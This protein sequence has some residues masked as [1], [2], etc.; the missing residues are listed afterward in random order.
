M[1]KPWLKSYGTNIPE[2]IDTGAFN[3]VADMFGYAFK[4]YATQTAF[5][6]LGAELSFSEVDAH[7]RNFAAYLQSEIGLKKGDRVAVMLPNILAFPIVFSG[8]MRIGAIQVNVNPNYTAHELQHQL[9]DSSAETIVVF[10]GSTPALASVLENTSVRHVIVAQL[11]DFGNDSTD[12]PDCDPSLSDAVRLPEAVSRGRDHDF[13]PPAISPDDT[14]F[15]Q[16]TGGTTGLSKGAVLSHGNLVANTEQVKAMIPFAI[17]PAE[18]VVVT[19]LPLY[20]IFGLMVNLITYFP[21][22]ARNHL[23][24]N[25]S[26]EKELIGAYRESK[27]SVSTGV[28]TLFTKLLNTPGFHDIDF[29]NCRLVMGGGTPTLPVTSERWKAA[30]GSH[31]REAYGMSETSPMISVNP[32]TYDD[33]TGTVGLPVPS[34]DIKLLGSGDV[35]ASIG[36]EGEVCVKGPQVMS[37]YW[38]KDDDKHEWYTPDGYFRTGDIGMFDEMGLLKIVDR[39]KDLVIVSGFNVF[40]TEI[41]AS[42][43]RMD[44]VVEC[45]AIGIP[46]EKTGEAIRLFVVKQSDADITE[47]DVINHC[48]TCLTRYKVP[49]Q[50]E[51]IDALPKSTVGKILRRTLREG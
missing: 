33:F 34:T 4:N 40:P 10:S 9:V 35:E 25:P 12:S 50:V 21:L 32:M 18:E 11:G 37:G 31:I 42:V 47:Q 1:N 44:G 19:A 20:H 36:E 22:G 29:S 43:A 30:T 13:T 23:V 8:I 14:L 2:E 16:Y 45:A 46:D 51:F 5:V 41:E 28:N 7:S 6:S 38:G 39:K 27:F 48:R 17:R 3:S 26:N 15:L 49:H 24:A